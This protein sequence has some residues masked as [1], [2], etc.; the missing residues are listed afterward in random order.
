[1][2]RAGARE[3]TDVRAAADGFEGGEVH[4]GAGVRTRGGGNAARRGEV[5]ALPRQCS[6]LLGGALVVAAVMM[7]SRRRQRALQ[8]LPW[9]QS[10]GG[11][12]RGKQKLENDSGR[13]VGTE[14]IL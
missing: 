5:G 10:G 8:M 6:L 11:S 13:K 9:W 12:V 4:T 14:F 2:G 3:G 7:G 1:V